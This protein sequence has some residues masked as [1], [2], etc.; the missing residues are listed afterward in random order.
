MTELERLWLAYCLWCACCGGKSRPDG[1][2]EQATSKKTSKKDAEKL[3]PIKSDRSFGIDDILIPYID[4]DSAEDREK[5]GKKSSVAA[6]K[7]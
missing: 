4:A 5:L 2:T 7:A 3:G 1:Q 6:G